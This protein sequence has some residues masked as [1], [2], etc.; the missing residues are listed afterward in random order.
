MIFLKFLDIGFGVDS[1]TAGTV[2]RLTK[3][4]SPILFQ[5]ATTQIL[6]MI[7]AL[8]PSSYREKWLMTSNSE[9]SKKAQSSHRMQIC[10]LPTRLSRLVIRFMPFDDKTVF[11]RGHSSSSLRKVQ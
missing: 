2:A 11:F 6:I 8:G 10:G 1:S 3:V 7:L 5:S 4:D 9:R